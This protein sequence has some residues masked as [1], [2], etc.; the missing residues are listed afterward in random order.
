MM[1]LEG[2]TL[3][4][5]GAAAKAESVMAAAIEEAQRNADI[6]LARLQRSRAAVGSPPPRV[7]THAGQVA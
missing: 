1:E 4:R 5:A 6:M 2:L 7:A 3:W